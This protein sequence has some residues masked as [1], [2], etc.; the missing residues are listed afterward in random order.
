MFIFATVASVVASSDVKAQEVAAVRVL[1]PVLAATL[2]DSARQSPTLRALVDELALS[3]LIVHILGA[4]VYQSR[5]LAGTMHFV[6][7][8]G[9]RRYLRITVD[10]G[11]PRDVRAAILAHELQH[12]VEVARAR[13]VVDVRSLGLLYE[14]IGRRSCACRRGACYETVDAQR[15]EARVLMEMRRA[16]TTDDGAANR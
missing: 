13:W 2:A 4:P 3:D 9:G 5:R 10:E 7:T 11:L 1:P 14:R 6:S 16:A 12:A 8:V 15:T